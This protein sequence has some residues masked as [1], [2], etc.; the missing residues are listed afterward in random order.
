MNSNNYKNSSMQTGPDRVEKNPN[1]IWVSLSVFGLFAVSFLHF[2]LPFDLV[3]EL[4][5]Q[6]VQVKHRCILCR[7]DDW[8]GMFGKSRNVQTVTC[9]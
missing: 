5:P 6:H 2:S 3:A 9:L 8:F 7:R 4:V 1:I